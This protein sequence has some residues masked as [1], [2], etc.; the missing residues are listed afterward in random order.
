MW[1]KRRSNWGQKLG[2][3]A[4]TGGYGPLQLYTSPSGSKEDR[5]IE[6]NP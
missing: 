6:L 2:R 1:G 4:S 3:W 5:K